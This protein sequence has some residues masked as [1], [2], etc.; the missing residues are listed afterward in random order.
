MLSLFFLSRSRFLSLS[1]SLSLPLSLFLC[2]L[3]SPFLSLSLSLSLAL[4]LALSVPLFLSL[5]ISSL[6]RLLSPSLSLSLSS[7]QLFDS[8]T[9][10][11][12]F[13]REY[14][15]NRPNEL[16][17]CVP[18]SISGLLFRSFFFFQKNIGVEMQVNITFVFYLFTLHVFCVFYFILFYFFLVMYRWGIDAAKK[19][20][21]TVSFTCKIWY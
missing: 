18:F 5:S 11:P 19:K 8:C 7:R 15:V 4:S 3:V 16:G 21:Y 1:F 6:P 20:S 2:L 10:K 14:E 17:M 13:W 9:S 12:R